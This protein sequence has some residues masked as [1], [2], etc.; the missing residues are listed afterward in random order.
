LAA[1]FVAAISSPLGRRAILLQRIAKDGGVGVLE[2][3]A[4]TAD[5]RSAQFEAVLLPLVH[6]RDV[7]DRFLGAIS[8][9]QPPAWLG[10]GEIVALSLTRREIVWPDGRPHSLTTRAG[11]PPALASHAS[12]GRIV[13]SE[14]RQ[15]RVLDGGLGLDPPQKT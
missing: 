12:H 5:G 14:R 3:E 9:I 1:S 15:F 8:A 7:V 13:R 2:M 6:T 11:Q 4:R 10:G